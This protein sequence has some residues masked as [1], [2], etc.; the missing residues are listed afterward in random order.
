MTTDNKTTQSLSIYLIKKSVSDQDV[1]NEEGLDNETIPGVGKLYY[2]S[3][4]KKPPAWLNFF[5]DYKIDGLFSSS[6]SAVLIVSVSNRT[7]AI[8][9]GPA[10]RHFIR[11]GTWEER[12]GL[13]V[14]LNS[15]QIDS[16]RSID[17]ETLESDGIRTRIQSSKPTIT[18]SF[19]FNTDKDLVRSVT[20]LSKDV[21]KYGKNLSGKDSLNVGLKCNL[22]DIKEYLSNYLSQFSDKSYKK[23]FPWIDKLREI[24]DISKIN[25][26]EKKLLEEVNKDSPDKL[27]LTVPEI[28]NWEDHGGFRYSQSKRTDLLDDIHVSTFKTHLSE[29]NLTLEHLKNNCVYRFS[30]SNEYLKNNWKIYECIFFE[31]SGTSETC[32]LT[33]GK[34]YAVNNSLVET[35]KAYYDGMSKE[36]FGID[37]IEY[38]HL[39]EDDYNSKLAD[40][41]NALSMDKNLIN[42]E[43]RSSFEFC[44][45]Y[46]K[47][48]QLI[49]IK[50]Y[51]QSSA[52]SHLFNQGYVSANFLLD[53]DFRSNINEKLDTKYKI[54]DLSSRPN[55]IIGEYTVIFGIISKSDN[56]LEIPF[57]SKLTLMHV[58]KDLINLGFKVSLVKIKNAKP[59]KVSIESQ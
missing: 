24:T 44:D 32:F 25:N 56:S 47:N 49:H 19:G 41:N 3:S 43:G 38:N 1:I 17:T 7:F 54:E 42:I 58:T 20:G 4:S 40:K 18:E 9:F 51:S 37:F 21:S 2:K 57:F 33:G 36:T 13:L 53:K 26:L 45:V 30:L 12:F 5:Q 48:K 29:T 34:W 11:K 14:T 52:L 39:D 28:L 22:S 31:Y 50:R 6:A 27:W 59:E 8:P 35:V 16:I 10:G 15:V 55:Q 46:T 23:Y